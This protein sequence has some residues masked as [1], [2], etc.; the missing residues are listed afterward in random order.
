MSWW[1]ESSTTCPDPFRHDF[2]KASAPT[3]AICRSTTLVNSST[4]TRS[5]R[6]QISLANPE[7]NFSPLLNTLNGLSQEGTSPNPTA[8]SAPV[9]WLKS[10]IGAIQS[11]IGLLLS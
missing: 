10:P 4:T 9:T 6:S 3:L 1:Q 8:D 7:R 11:T 5:G 2:A